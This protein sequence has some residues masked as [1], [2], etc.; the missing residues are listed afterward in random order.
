MDNTEEIVVNEEVNTNEET[1]LAPEKDNEFAV[2][3]AIGAVAAVATGALIKL[4]KKL[5]D[6]AKPARDNFK[7]KLKEKRARRKVSKDLDAADKEYVED[8]NE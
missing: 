8:E 7:S 5:S 3:L 6:K 1:G 2:G 4:G